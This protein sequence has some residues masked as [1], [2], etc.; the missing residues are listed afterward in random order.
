MIEH[1]PRGPAAH[2]LD[3]VRAWTDE[4]PG[5]HPM[6]PTATGR[7]INRTRFVFAFFFMLAG[8]SS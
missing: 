2:R 5:R 1:P 6:N 7:L 4:Q 8:I 3:A